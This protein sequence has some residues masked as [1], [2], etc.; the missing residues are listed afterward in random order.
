MHVDPFSDRQTKGSLPTASGE[1]FIPG[2]KVHASAVGIAGAIGEGRVSP[3]PMRLDSEK[4]SIKA[5]F[6]TSVR[7]LVVGA[8]D[9]S[10]SQDVID[11]IPAEINPFVSARTRPSDVN[12]PQTVATPMKFDQGLFSLDAGVTRTLII[13]RVNVQT[14]PMEV[15]MFFNVR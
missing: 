9:F 3:H 12:L 4:T 7:E 14:S 10:V 15:A 1:V 2:V 8:A 6:A 11:Q 13:S 5:L